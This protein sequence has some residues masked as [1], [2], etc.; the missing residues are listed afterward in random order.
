MITII[1]DC[2]PFYIRF[3]HDGIEDIINLYSSFMPSLE[4]LENPYTH[5]KLPIDQANQI[6]EL[7]PLSK[8][9]TLN[10]HRVSG[11]ISKPGLYYRAHKD[12]IN[13]RFSLNYSIIVLDNKCV[14]SWYSDEDCKDYKIDI[15]YHKKGPLHN[16]GSSR[17]CENFDKTKHT[18]IK[19]MTARPLECT[20]FNTDI[21]HDW[22]NSQSENFRAILT[23]RA[24][25]E[26]V[27]NIYF[28]DVKKILYA[29]KNQNMQD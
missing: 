5:A 13:H 26:T 19:Q 9:L 14:T 22:D 28:E 1:E 20:L 16:K 21:Y 7:V 8:Y 11:F 4:S 15:L 2:S 12:G 18:P 24:S 25:A 10:E 29:L 17:E 23:L 6:I 27:G 3:T